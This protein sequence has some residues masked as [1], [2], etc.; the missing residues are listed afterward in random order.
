MGNKVSDWASH[1][2]IVEDR[3]RLPTGWPTH[4]L[5]AGCDRCGSVVHMSRPQQ[6]AWEP[7][8]PGSEHGNSVPAQ[9]PDVVFVSTGPVAIAIS[10][11]NQRRPCAAG[12]TSS[13]STVWSPCLRWDEPTWLC[14]LLALL[15]ASD[16]RRRALVC[17][18]RRGGCH[19]LRDSASAPKQPPC[20]FRYSAS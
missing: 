2:V 6:P 5:G 4:V 7:G 14:Q 9:F 17:G 18:V 11:R 19:R 20:P 3:T 10:L 13:N 1:L 16:M 12:C 8:L 15:R